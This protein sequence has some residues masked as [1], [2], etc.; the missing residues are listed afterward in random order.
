MIANK[1][2]L[3]KG[4]GP[5]PSPFRPLFVGIDPVS[6]TI[7]GFS[8]FTNLLSSSKASKRQERM[9]NKQ[10]DFNRSENQLNRIF[11]TDERVAAQEFQSSEALKSF[12]RNELSRIAQNNYNTSERLASQEYNSMQ[13]QVARAR[14]AGI[15][16][17]LALGSSTSVGTAG[18]AGSSNTSSPASG[19]GFGNGSSIGAPCSS[20]S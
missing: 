9:F 3:N 18:N 4:A 19:A 10:L 1:F 2:S 13:Q 6:A 7:G 16:P 8:A 15:N 11:Q 14:A 20:Y 17:S 5:S 12:E